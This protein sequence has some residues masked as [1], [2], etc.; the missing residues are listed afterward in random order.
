M[1]TSWFR[2]VLSDLGGRCLGRVQARTMQ[3]LLI[4]PFCPKTASPQTV[5]EEHCIRKQLFVQE[6]DQAPITITSNLK[7]VLIEARAPAG[8]WR[9][10]PAGRLELA[11]NQGARAP[12]C[13]PDLNTEAHQT[14]Q[15]PTARPQYGLT[16]STGAATAHLL[17]RDWV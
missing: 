16:H 8:V 14:D 13:R 15:T 9:R 17:P 7:L 3:A 5:L 2:P 11:P 1:S 10:Q 4:S 12:S 6:A